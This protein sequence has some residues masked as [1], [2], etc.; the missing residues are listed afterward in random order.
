MIKKN[1]EDGEIQQKICKVKR[2]G[3]KTI[4]W[5]LWC[6]QKA[7]KKPHKMSQSLALIWAN[8]RPWTY[9]LEGRTG[10]QDKGHCNSET[11]NNDNDFP[12]PPLREP[13]PVD[14]LPVSWGNGNAQTIWGLLEW[15]LKLAV[16]PDTGKTSQSPRYSRLHEIQVINAVLTQVQ[17][18]GI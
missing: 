16:I 1:F 3:E 7:E 8:L 15:E 10:L 2:D 11:R 9:V 17:I 6:Y 13:L 5:N 12:S 18:I 14:L 4:K